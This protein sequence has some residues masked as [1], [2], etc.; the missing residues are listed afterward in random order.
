MWCSFTADLLVRVE[1][2]SERFTPVD[3]LVHY[4]GCGSHRGVASVPTKGS[5]RPRIYNAVLRCDFRRHLRVAWASVVRRTYC[6][7]K[8]DKILVATKA[9]LVNAVPELFG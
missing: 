6:S 3:S 9:E 7:S 4:G 2:P 5:K 1:D 8:N